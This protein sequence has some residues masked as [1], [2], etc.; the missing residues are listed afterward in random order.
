MHVY[1]AIYIL[2]ESAREREREICLA[3][4]QYHIMNAEYVGRTVHT[5]IYIY[6]DGNL[7]ICENGFAA[8]ANRRNKIYIDQKPNR[9]SQ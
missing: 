2:C 3:Y 9:P 8:G 5:H 7:K 1:S 4:C 6:I